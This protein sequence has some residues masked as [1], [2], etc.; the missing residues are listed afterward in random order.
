MIV[1]KVCHCVIQPKIQIIFF[2]GFIYLIERERER[3]REAET[4][5]IYC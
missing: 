4:P 1:M 5:L 2:K 3:E